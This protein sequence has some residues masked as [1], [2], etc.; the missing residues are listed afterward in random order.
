MVI[1]P[2]TH[3]QSALQAAYALADATE[4]ASAGMMLRVSVIPNPSVA[5]SFALNARA[6]CLNE[7][8]RRICTTVIDLIE[9]L[10]VRAA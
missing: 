1:E 5:L 7:N 6:E 4:W 3:E 9:R 8:G 10:V 2:L